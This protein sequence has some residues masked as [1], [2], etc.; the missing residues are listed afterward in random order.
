VVHFLG[1]K[2]L[3][4]QLRAGT[5]I[6]LQTPSPAQT[7]PKGVKYEPPMKSVELLKKEKKRSV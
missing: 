5:L 6:Q 3:T 1:R 7:N 2:S 4:S